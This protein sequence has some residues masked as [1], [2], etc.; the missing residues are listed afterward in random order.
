MKQYIPKKPVRRGFK[1]W[2]VA[3]SENGYF[4]DVDVY[5]GRP[6][7][8]VRSEQGLGA[9]VVLQLTEPY[10]HKNYH[11]FCD[12]FFT[13]PTL[14]AE[15]LQHGL[16][17]C[18]TVRIDRREFP[19]ELKGLRLERGCHDFRQKGKLSAIIWQDKRQVSV[20]STLTTP[21]ETL[22]IRRKERDGT[23]T[24]LRC[25]TAITT[26]N[27]HMAGVDKG[28][29]LRRYYR[30]RLK[31][32]KNYKYIF[33]FMLDT[34]ITNAHILFSKF[35]SQ[36]AKNMKQ[37]EFRLV[38]AQALVGDYCGRLRVGR[39]RSV[40]TP[41]P[42]SPSHFPR[43]RSQKRRCVFCGNYRNPPCRRESRWYCED[44]E[45]QPT[46]CLTGSGDDSDCWRMWHS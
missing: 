1:V 12:N 31:F 5:V 19:A 41:H 9:R 30:L 3:D 6:S 14:F 17:A 21:D 16:Y 20:L 29:Q 10:R 43:K 35:A 32:M 37:K 4:L 46:L 18:G 7:D 8:G 33:F 40:A 25:P 2:V 36:S 44:C 27:M 26:Y 15:L 45:G 28:D 38:L 13:S 42:Q 11:V 39:P 23:A 22:P 34:A 24:T